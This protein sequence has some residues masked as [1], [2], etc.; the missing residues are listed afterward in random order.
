M[1]GFA[2]HRKTLYLLA[3][4]LSVLSLSTGLLLLHEFRV[5]AFV[6]VLVMLL[7]E[8]SR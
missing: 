8:E 3:L 7:W 4:T 5:V 1:N 6:A 2:E